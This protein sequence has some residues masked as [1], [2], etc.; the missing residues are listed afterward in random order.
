MQNIDK[1]WTSILNN[2]S[3]DEINEKL[4]EDKEE[5]KCFAHL[6]PE[7]DRFN[8]F[9]Y[10]KLN[11]CKVVIIGQDPYHGKGEAHG[12][13]FSVRKGVNIPPSLRNIKKE[14]REDTGDEFQ[15]GDL[16]YW[17]EQ[18]ILLLNSALSVRERCANSHK[19]FW[20]NYT[21]NIIK[22]ISEESENLIFILWGRFAQG[23]KKFID[24]DK[25][26]ILEANHPSPLSANRGGFF[27]CKHFSKIND[28]L[29]KQGK[30][31]INWSN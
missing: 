3:L 8:A 4:R 2:E 1:S 20:M 12:L 28:I 30:G 27:G 19:D 21:D 11:E 24:L 23:K 26:T 16:T 10:F 29:E 15:E 7:E 13:C 17:A 18:G 31:K 14:L 9:K 25:H 22:R 6:P 5:Y